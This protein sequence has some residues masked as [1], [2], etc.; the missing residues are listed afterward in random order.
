[1]AE[2]ECIL[3]GRCLA[4]CPL[5]RAT[6]R[7]ELS[8]RAK[9]FLAQAGGVARAAG[10]DVE[11]DGKTAAR[12]AALCLGCGRC[13][14]ACSQGLSADRL[15]A[16]LRSRHPGFNDWLWSTWVKRP[17]ILWP[18][19]ATAGRL[20][21]RAVP[22]RIAAAVREAVDTLGP[23]KVTPW[24]RPVFPACEK[25][26]S[27]VVFPGCT[28]RTVRTAWTGRAAALAEGAGWE[29]GTAPGFVCCGKSL[30]QAG[31]A[32]AARA[33]R[34]ANVAAWRGAGR[35]EMLV[36]CSSC[37]AGL[38]EYGP[39]LFVDEAEREAWREAVTPLW[40]ILGEVGFEPTESAPSRVHV[41]VPCRGEVA[42]SAFIFGLVGERL[43]RVVDGCCGFGGVMQLTAPELTRQVGEHCLSDLADAPGQL[44]TGCAG[45]AL[46]LGRTA[47]EGFPDL[48]A[49]HWLDMILN[50][51]ESE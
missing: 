36:F 10:S 41:H 12:F 49:G 22:G 50:P 25:T 15:A 7:E 11:P 16:E 21:P 45:C 4:V 30:A 38:V 29:T 14:K 35:P 28:A 13:S 23:S 43:G 9:Y 40:S 27:A 5:V 31:Q 6:A 20:L 17:Q 32:G 37:R 1:M 44:V 47:A 34:V 19:A 51:T 2:R 26:R 46:H 3:C 39:D 33:M 18:A 8:P 42:E 48:D 24:L